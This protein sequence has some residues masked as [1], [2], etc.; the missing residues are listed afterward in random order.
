M[1][2]PKP[3]AMHCFDVL[4]H[5]DAN[6]LISKEDLVAYAKR[7]FPRDAFISSPRFP[8]W[9]DGGFGSYLEREFHRLLVG[10]VAMQRAAD[11]NERLAEDRAEAIE[12][13]RKAEEDRDYYRK[14]AEEANLRLAL[15]V[16][17]AEAVEAAT[18]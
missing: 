18:V 15:S 11:E 1:A 9:V 14:Q 12:D 7:Q 13:L 3:D 2:Q 8:K 17:P 5:R 6:P 16:V 10:L 4:K